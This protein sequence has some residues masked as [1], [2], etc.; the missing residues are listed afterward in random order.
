MPIARA[1]GNN[2]GQRVNCCCIARLLFEMELG[3]IFVFMELNK[4]SRLQ[5]KKV[6]N[7]TI[8]IQLQF[9]KILFPEFL[10]LLL[11]LF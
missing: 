9:I 7:Y 8:N 4:L 5:G 10:L 11:E 6:S 1:R 2:R 3:G